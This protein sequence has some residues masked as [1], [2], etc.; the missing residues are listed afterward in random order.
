MTNRTSCFQIM[1]QKSG[2]PC[3]VK[4]LLKIALLAIPA[5]EIIH[6]FICS[7]DEE[8]EI[9]DLKNLIEPACNLFMYTFF[10]DEVEKVKRALIDPDLE[11][12]E[13]PIIEGHVYTAGLLSNLV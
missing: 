6:L 3:L 11:T 7:D 13:I 5:F 1:T 2:R 10:G 12:V 4:G 9:L 8:E